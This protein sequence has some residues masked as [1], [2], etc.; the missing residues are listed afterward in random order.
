MK[1]IKDILMVLMT[2]LLVTSCNKDGD[3][4]FLSSPEGGE[5]TAS[6]SA[7]ALSKEKNANI[8]LSLA[9]TKST[10]QVSDANVSAPNVLTST[11]QTSLTKDFS[12]VSETVEA[13]P[14]KA[15]YGLDL[16]ST[17]KNLGAEPGTSTPLYFRIKTT[18]AAN[19]EP[20]YSNTVQV[21]VTPYQIDMSVGYVLTSKKE[22]S[23]ATLYSPTSNGVYS[24]FIGATAW[25]NWLLQEG[26]GTEWGNDG[27]SGTPFLLSS[28]VSTHWNF[29]YPGAAGCYYSIVDVNNKVWSALS[30]PSLSVSGDIAGDMTYDRPTNRWTYTFSS[31]SAGTKTIKIAGSGKQYNYK[32]G[33]DDAAAIETPVGFGM[34]G[35]NITFG[36]S[37]SDITVNVPAKGTCTLIL[38]LSNPK[39]WT[40]TAIEG[41]I[42]GSTVSK[43]LWL[44]GIDDGISG[45]WT[46][47]NY[48]SLYSEDGLSYAGVINVNSKWGYM[49]YT[50]KDN[51]SSKYGLSTGTAASGTLE[52]N[53]ANNIPAPSAG[54]Y[55]FDVSMKGLTY[56][57]TAVTSVAYAGFNTK[58][59]AGGDWT[60][61]NMTPS[62]ETGV[63]TATVTLKGASQWGAKIY[64][65]GSWDYFFGGSAGSLTY[66]GSGIT[67][68][69][70]LGAGTYTLTVNLLKGT[71]TL[72]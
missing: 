21:D 6:E 8:V 26:D 29:W 56:T 16:N 4:I 67:D 11:L 34:N 63:Y 59:D 22:M 36:S 42:G 58:G 18:Y 72:K 53:G 9:W 57:T 70:T 71:Y 10:L 15:F 23:G 47:D 37:A 1:T 44:S 19:E 68:D 38:D 54:L 64:L 7:V 33:T 60:L 69:A 2:L 40:C 45:S 20:V 55:L 31:T 17:A 62:S 13:N 49:F 14:S 66:K 3:S 32:T 61:V 24:G 25:A 43:Y 65:N 35:S 39:A 50:E 48:L 12:K 5:L 30:I 27:V 51:W 46:F 28:D 41:S 52:A